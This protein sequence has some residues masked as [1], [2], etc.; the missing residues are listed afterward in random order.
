MARHGRRA[1]EALGVWRGPGGGPEERRAVCCGGACSQVAVGVGEEGEGRRGQ[2]RG[3]GHEM[4]WK[5]AGK[6]EGTTME[7][8]EA[9]VT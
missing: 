5:R 8:R 7:L 2:K 9:L 4:R 1:A 3:I 6:Q